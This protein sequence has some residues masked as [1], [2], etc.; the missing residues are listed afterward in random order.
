MLPDAGPD[1]AATSDDD[2]PRG[3]PPSVKDIRPRAAWYWIGAAILVLG[4]AGATGWFVSSVVAAVNVAQDHQRVS[5]PGERTLTFSEPGTYTIYGET[6]EYVSYADDLVTPTITVKSSSG[7]PVPVDDTTSRSYSPSSSYTWNGYRGYSLG[8]IDIPSAGPY[9]VSVSDLVVRDS[10]A[11]SGGSTGGSSGGTPGTSRRTTT[12]YSYQASYSVDVARIAVGKSTDDRAVAGIFASLGLGALAAIIGTVV[13]IVTGVKR[14]GSRRKLFPPPAR[15]LAYPGMGFPPAPGPYGSPYGSPYGGPPRPG[16]Y[17]PSPYGPLPYG[18]PPPSGPPGG[19]GP[20]GGAPYGAAPYGPP[21]G[22]GPYGAPPTGP[23]PYGPP[24]GAPPY[25]P[26][27]G[28]PPYGAGP[29]GAAPPPPGAPPF[30]PPP[31]GSRNDAPSGPP[32]PFATPP[33]AAGAAPSRPPFGPPPGASG[34]PAGGAYDPRSAAPFA[35]VDRS[36]SDAPAP[37]VDPWAPPASASPAFVEPPVSAIPG[38]QSF[39]PPAD[40]AAADLHD[41]PEDAHEPREPGIPDR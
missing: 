18:G 11:G 37:E 6:T 5:I 34:P 2:P 35:P 39:E 40:P 27:P 20:Y 13:L 22:A 8:T 1:P 14:S 33:G 15:P 17:G 28:A 9:V 3:A 24:P 25:G 30:G 16:P 31:G 29:Y 21:P 32:G 36:I 7:T 41:E 26:P 23:S 38:E 4:L 12:T 10:G 19:A